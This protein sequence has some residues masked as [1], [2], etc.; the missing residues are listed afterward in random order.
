MYMYSP[1]HPGQEVE[2]W[3]GDEVSSI[4]PGQALSPP[5][6]PEVLQLSPREGGHGAHH[7][8]LAEELINT[9]EEL[10][11]RGRKVRCEGGRV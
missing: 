5:L 8:S 1:T 6:L 10:E 11:R 3:Y 7:R 9:G 2:L 4:F